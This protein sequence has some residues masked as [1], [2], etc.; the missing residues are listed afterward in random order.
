MPISME[1]LCA[2]FQS[3]GVLSVSTAITP[4]GIRLTEWFLRDPRQI[5]RRSIHAIVAYT[6]SGYGCLSSFKFVI[7]SQRCMT[8]FGLLRIK[9]REFLRIVLAA[10]VAEEF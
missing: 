10:S 8:E 9:I 4:S 5:M 7:Y 3:A 2:V 6:G 1:T